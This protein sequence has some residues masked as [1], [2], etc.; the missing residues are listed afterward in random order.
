MRRMQV[1]PRTTHAITQRN[2]FRVFVHLP[3]W[4][5]LNSSQNEHLAFVRDISPRGVFFYSQFRPAQENRLS[6]MLQYLSGD[7]RIRLHLK[8][9]I[10]RVEQ[11]ASTALTGIAVAFDSPQEDVPNA[12]SRAA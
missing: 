3:A 1:S 4:L 11:A 12:S 6:F 7:S 10:V 2:A 8:G 9:K 5:S